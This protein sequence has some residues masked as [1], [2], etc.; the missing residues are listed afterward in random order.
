MHF[1]QEEK[2][3]L[4]I[5]AIVIGGLVILTR[6]PLVIWPD[7]TKELFGRALDVQPLV[8]L[9]GLL[10]MG[11]GLLTA[12]A[13]ASETFAIEIVMWVIAAI[14]FV[15]G[16]LY[17]VIPQLPKQLWDK[18]AVP[19]SRGVLRTMAG[20]GVLVG[21]FVLVLGL[22]WMMQGDQ[23][24]ATMPAA[25][26]AP[27]I[28]EAVK[29]NGEQIAELRESFPGIKQEAW[30]NSKQIAALRGS[31]PAVKQEAS[32]NGK[33]IAALRKS[34]EDLRREVKGLR[35]EIKSERAPRV[36]ER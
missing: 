9:I 18:I 10:M 29:Q 3:M 31:L 2:T 33:Q 30:E 5:I 7:K 15:F 19:R 11:L 22:T 25:A 8:S 1:I 28:E 26:I 20:A 6:L 35:D 36:I 21:L 13:A 34:L 23:R 17:V 4:P 12:Y 14:M 24:P 32:E 27:G 16:M